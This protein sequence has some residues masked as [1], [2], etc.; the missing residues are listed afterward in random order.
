MP[1]RRVRGDM[2][3]VLVVLASTRP[4]SSRRSGRI[5]EDV[6]RGKGWRR[7][8]YRNLRVGWAFHM[9]VAP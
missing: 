3:S 4:W 8:W 9:L 6:W 2:G 5:G 1:L 7:A